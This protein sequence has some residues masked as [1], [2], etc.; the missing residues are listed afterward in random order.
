MA[1]ALPVNPAGRLLAGLDLR[2]HR[3]LAVIDGRIG[4]TGSQN[5]V[6]PD[7]GNKVGDWR[8]LMVRLVGLSVSHF[9]AVILED[10]EFEAEQA[11]NGEEYFPASVGE[12]CIP[13]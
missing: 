13:L 5:V 11:V 1:P 2:N 3:K 10:W 9:Q 6:R 12:E 7:Y 8:D 4:Y